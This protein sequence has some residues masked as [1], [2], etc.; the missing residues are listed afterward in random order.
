MI[1]KVHNYFASY[2]PTEGVARCDTMMTGELAHW[3]ALWGVTWTVSNLRA[4][5]PPHPDVEQI[6]VTTLYRRPALMTVSVVEGVVR[7]ASLNED[8]R[9]RSIRC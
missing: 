8:L 6:V 2:D 4:A 3:F 5:D 1:L 7:P 9:R